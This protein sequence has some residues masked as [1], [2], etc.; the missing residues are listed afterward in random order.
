L[1]ERMMGLERTTF[2][3]MASVPWIESRRPASPH[4]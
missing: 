2:F 4:C 3:C 1:E